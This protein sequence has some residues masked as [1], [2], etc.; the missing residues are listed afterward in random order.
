[1]TDAHIIIAGDSN[2]LGYLNTGAA[3]YAPTVRVQIW[4]DTNGDNVGD[5][6][7]Y[8]RPGVN[9]GTAT[10]PAV[11]GAEVQI[12]NRW[13]A[14]NPTGYLWIVKNGE[15]VKGGT[16]LYNDWHEGAAYFVSTTS[17]AA[18]AMANLGG[19]PFA[20]SEYQ[21]AFVGLGENDANPAMAGGYLS[22][23]TSFDFSARAAWHVDE[24]VEY[25]ITTGAGDAA[26]NLAVRQAQWQAD[27]ADDHMTSFKTIG[28][29][30]RPDGVHYADHVALGNMV[31]DNWIL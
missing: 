29:E 2:A 18:H 1:M 21:M 7:N 11:W 3:P 28:M 15:T 19:G 24:L 25:R 27:M 14:D 5:A 8:M 4:A 12:A 9:T 13:L 31:Y 16:T 10:N 6:W 22:E 26:S 17:S 20:F 30:M 23:L